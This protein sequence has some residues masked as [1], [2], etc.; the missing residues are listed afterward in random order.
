MNLRDRV[1][2]ALA[3]DVASISPLTG[4]CVA[5]VARVDLRGGD[6]VVV[7][8]GQGA[9]VRLD[10]EAFMLRLLGE[11]LPTL[12]PRVLHD[13]A[14]LL[15]MSHIENDGGRSDAGMMELGEALGRLH[16][17]RGPAFGLEQETLIGPLPLPNP[18]GDSWTEFFGE[19][20]LRAMARGAHEAGRLGASDRSRVDRLCE[21]LGDLLGEEHTPTLVH[22]DLW[23][24]N[25][26]W[27]GG[28]LAG[29]IDPGSYFG[30][31]EVDL[32]MMDL[33]GGFSRAFWERYAEVRGGSEAAW[34]GFWGVRREVY[35]LFPLLVHARLFGGGYVG[36]VRRTLDRL[37]G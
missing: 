18:W 19:H 14:D 21:R 25:V 28:S 26:L 11:H 20:R 1:E 7:K 10:V 22:G 12:V 29:V 31:G 32:A 17:V 36:Q 27:R 34:E 9:G 30:V 15:I 16:G 4:G 8:W 23:S 35:Q 33:F 3:H 6:P 2:R 24:G 37:V 13:D 5:Q